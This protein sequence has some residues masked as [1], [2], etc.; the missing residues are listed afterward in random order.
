MRLSVIIPAFNEESN[1]A[2]VYRNLKDPLA[3]I[4]HEII[5]VDD[6][7]S[8]STFSEMEKLAKKDKNVKVV[9]FRRNFGQTAAWKAGFDAAKGDIVATIDADMQNDPKDIPKMIAKL[10]EGYDFVS[11][12]R[13]KRKDT[14]S[15]KIFSHLSRLFRR[16]II[17]DP[18]HD[19]G[20][21]LKVY[22]KECLNDLDLQGEMHRYIAELLILQGFKAGEV[23]VNH[24]PR[25]KGHTKYN[26]I[27]LPNGFLDLLVVAFW[28][29]YSRRPIHLFGRM[30]LLMGLL[31]SL[32]G[33]Y[34]VYIKFA[35]QASI[36]NRPLLLLS[37]LLVVLGLQFII[38]GLIADILMKLY[39][40]NDRKN[41]NIE[42]IING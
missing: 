24:F 37:V 11:G 36:A 22:R 23:K 39:Y 5:F 28:Q 1:I 31:G 21:S 20:C 6:G 10:D 34:L 33:L 18:I 26:L 7:S 13:S 16:L 27:R 4:E 42:R 9:K 35:F 19:S 40:T 3:K 17:A 38:F 12:W 41:N 25:K 8:D 30:G 32:I 15:K 29:R 2:D 14:F